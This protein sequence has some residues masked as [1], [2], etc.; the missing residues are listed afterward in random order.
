MDLNLGFRTRDF[1]PFLVLPEEPRGSL[2]MGESIKIYGM[3]GTLW[4][5]ITLPFRL[6]AR[7]VELLGRATGLALGFVLM[8]AGIALCSGSLVIL[9]VPVFLVGLLLTLRSLG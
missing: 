4:L 7:V 9:G 8:V 3:L 5:V 6:V 2:V 1:V